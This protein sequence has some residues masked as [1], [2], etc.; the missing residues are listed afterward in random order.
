M[1]ALEDV[2]LKNGDRLIIENVNVIIN[3]LDRVLVFARNGSGK[4]SLMKCLTGAERVK[5][6]EIK[7]HKY[8][9]EVKR[10]EL[11]ISYLPELFEFDDGI[12]VKQLFNGF[13]LANKVNGTLNESSFIEAIYST[14]KIKELEIQ[15]FGTLSKGE[16][17]RLLIAITLLVKYDCL[18]L[19]EPY[20]G[21]DSEWRKLIAGLIEESVRQIE[22]PVAIIISS[23]IYD[24]TKDL[25][26]N[27]ILTIDKNRV[28]VKVS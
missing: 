7:Y 4:S 17:K 1:I 27:K 13:Y 23:H 16:K 26:C 15:R 2:K 19:D 11:V 10:E 18:I 3:D 22:A 8:G 9:S 21:L 25:N 28:E 6:G 5:S 24:N 12:I 20:D 14:L